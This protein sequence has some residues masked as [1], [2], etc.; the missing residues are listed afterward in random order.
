MEEALAPEAPL[1]HAD[2]PNNILRQFSLSKGDTLLGFQE[3]ELVVE[4]DYQTP[5]IEHCYFETDTR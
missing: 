3:A 1:I 4:D 2:C 5:A